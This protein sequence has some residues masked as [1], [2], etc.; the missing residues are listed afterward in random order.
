MPGWCVLTSSF[1]RANP[2]IGLTGQEYEDFAS[3][4]VSYVALHA[5]VD[6]ATYF[7]DL[8]RNYTLEIAGKVAAASR[9][10]RP[11]VP[12]LLKAGRLGAPATVLRRAFKKP[13]S[14]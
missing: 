2:L 9:V 8:Y 12:V 13:R 1:A 10:R 4:L 3:A 7:L 5:T 11:L 6:Q 14:H